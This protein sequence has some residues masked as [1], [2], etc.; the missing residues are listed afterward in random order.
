MNNSLS[1][2]QMF[3]LDVQDA[4]RGGASR[5]EAFRQNINNYPG[6][7]IDKDDETLLFQDG[8]RLRQVDGG[9]KVF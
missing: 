8:S 6:W 9:L 1:D 4:M 5:M 3:A 2:A 7:S